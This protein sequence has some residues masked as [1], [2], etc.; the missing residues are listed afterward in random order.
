MYDFYQVNNVQS[1]EILYGIEALVKQAAGGFEIR[2]ET[3]FNFNNVLNAANIELGRLNAK[4]EELYREMKALVAELKEKNEE[5]DKLHR[6][7]TEKNIQ[8][9]DLADKDGL[10]KAYN[11]RFFKDYLEHQIS[12]Y[13]RNKLSLTLIMIDIDFF[14]KINDTYGHQ[15]G[16]QV[17]RELSAI[18]HKN[19]RTSDLVAR[20]GGEE[21]AIVLN[22]TDLQGAIIFAEKMRKMIADKLFILDEKTSIHITVS[23]GIGM[24]MPGMQSSDKL[25]ELADKMLYHSKHNGRNRVSVPRIESIEQ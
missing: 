10:T 7:V 16:D 15:A 9:Q 4:Y 19:I 5:L 13:Q 12:Q 18:L 24:L 6:E 2:L 22:A 1:D 14:K 23:M 11:H 3:E 17:L 21:F 25:I 20:Y 8:L